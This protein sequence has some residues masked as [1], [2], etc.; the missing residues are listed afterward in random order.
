MAGHLDD[1]EGLPLLRKVV[2]LPLDSDSVLEC[3][4]SA[5]SRLANFP[6]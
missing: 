5:C 4:L 3:I 1:L 2:Y 6:V